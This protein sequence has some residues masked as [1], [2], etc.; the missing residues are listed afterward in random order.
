MR[1][2]AKEMVQIRKEAAMF[3]I[4]LHMY[5]FEMPGWVVFFSFCT[6]MLLSQ[7]TFCLART[8]FLFFSFQVRLISIFFFFSKRSHL[9]CSQTVSFDQYQRLFTCAFVYMHVTMHVA[10]GAR[11]LSKRIQPLNCARCMLTFSFTFP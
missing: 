10:N 8:L 3:Y 11:Y 4:S 2:K 9:T 7:P 5:S 6:L 1:G